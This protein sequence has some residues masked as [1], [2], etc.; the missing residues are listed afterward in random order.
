MRDDEK[1]GL[2]RMP[3]FRN[4][5][6]QTFD[7]LME[8]AYSQTFPPQLELFH[9]GHSADFLHVVMEGAVELHAEWNGRKTVMAVVRPVS[10]FLLAACLRDTPYLMSARTLERSRVVLL[11][12]SDLRTAMRRDPDLAMAAMAELADGYR[13]MVCHAK[14]MKLRSARERIAAWILTQS[15]GSASLMLKIEKQQLAAYLGI[16]PESLSRTLRSM[17]ADGLLADGSRITITDRAS[18]RKLAILDPLMDNPAMVKG[19]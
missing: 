19:A 11:P 16:T 2:R 14:G 5:M 12:A 15:E 8:V 10:T 7:G 9:Q 18:L 3:L 13:S 17:Q 1:P 4:M 6:S